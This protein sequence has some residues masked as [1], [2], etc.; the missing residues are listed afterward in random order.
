[1]AD[2][3]LFFWR[4]KT[5]FRLV[6]RYSAF[7]D[8]RLIKTLTF[9][10]IH[11]VTPRQYKTDYKFSIL[12]ARGPYYVTEDGHN[13]FWFLLFLNQASQNPLLPLNTDL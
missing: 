11:I 10:G 9:L 5:D 2:F 4:K 3:V 6:F 7:H 12:P 13:R 8:V 1:M